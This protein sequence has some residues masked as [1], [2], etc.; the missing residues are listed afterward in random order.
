MKKQTDNLYIQLLIASR[1]INESFQKTTFNEMIDV[2]KQSNIQEET[3]KE[4]LA[5]MLSRGLIEHV[6][7]GSE[8]LY[9]ITEFGTYFFNQL[10][11]TNHQVDSLFKG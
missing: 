7:K 2:V 3:L 10:R 8:I 6:F 1:L 11:N 5:M 4:A 9:S